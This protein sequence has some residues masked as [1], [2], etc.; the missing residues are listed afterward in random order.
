M[1]RALRSPWLGPLIIAACGVIGFVM[2]GSEAPRV[3][4]EV[5]VTVRATRDNGSP[6]DFGRGLPDPEI[7]VV[8]GDRT[9][10]SCP[11]VK[12]RLQATC[13]TSVRIVAGAGP[14]RVLVAD[15]DSGEDD[16]IGEL[17]LALDGSARSTITGAGALQTVEAVTRGGEAP[18]LR[19]R[20]LWITL[21]LG[22]A[23]A[24]ALALY[25]RRLAAAG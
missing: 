23:L 17:V 24:L 15:G 22:V 21:G 9:L 19:Y 4:E 18:G 1:Q 13:A 6:W 20:P 12:D 25:R 16:A 14:L 7:R 11:E 8:Q 3:L 5:R 2:S 10:A